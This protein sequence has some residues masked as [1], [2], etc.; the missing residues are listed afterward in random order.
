M[1]IEIPESVTAEGMVKAA[2][3]PAIANPLTGPTVAEMA[4]GVIVSG[5]LM[6]D[7]DG[8]TGTQTKGESRRFNSR[9][10]YQRFGRTTNDVAPLMYTY[11]PQELATPGYSAN[12]VYETL[13]EGTKGFLVLGY[14]LDAEDN[15]PFVAGDVV[16]FAPVECGE[17]FKQA[18]G[19]DEFAPLTVQQELVPTGPKVK[20][21]TIASA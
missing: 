15:A 12:E 18:R 19:S 20:D 6:P 1:T 7:W 8:F 13:A 5:Y 16:D 3:I 9:Q 17:Q 14:G 21:R 2:F 11:I 4:A 10:T